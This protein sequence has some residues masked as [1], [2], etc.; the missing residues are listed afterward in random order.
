[1][2]RQEVVADEGRGEFPFG[3]EAAHGESQFSG[4]PPVGIDEAEAARSGGIVQHCEAQIDRFQFQFDVRP[5]FRFAF[6]SSGAEVGMADGQGSVAAFRS[7]FRGDSQ[8]SQVGF[9]EKSAINSS[10]EL[11]NFPQRPHGHSF[12]KKLRDARDPKVSTDGADRQH[13]GGLDLPGGHIREKW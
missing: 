4:A 13:R 7:D 1:M 6:L 2:Y 9:L 11:Q 12:P 5:Q 8:Y 10:A 3:E